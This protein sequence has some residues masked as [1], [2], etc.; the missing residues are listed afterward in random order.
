MVIPMMGKNYRRG[1]WLDSPP[2]SVMTLSVQG[3]KGKGIC[4]VAVSG[5]R[6]NEYAI[7]DAVWEFGSRSISLNQERLMTPEL[8]RNLAQKLAEE[9]KYEEY[10]KL[11]MELM[12]P[13]QKKDFVKYIE[14]FEQI[15]NQHGLEWIKQQNFGWLSQAA[16]AYEAVGKLK[17]AAAV[18]YDIADHYRETPMSACGYIQKAIQLDGGNAIYSD[19]DHK[20]CNYS[21]RSKN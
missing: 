19:F 3:D 5:N 8:K 13:F 9:K 18:N 16:I 4:Q 2:R 14:L 20:I 6:P 12:Q 17:E 10:K 1:G 15:R 11:H 7:D 21:V